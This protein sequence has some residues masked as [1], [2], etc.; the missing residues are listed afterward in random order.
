MQ[1][2]PPVH[3]RRPLRPSWRT[4]TWWG[5]SDP[6][7]QAETWY[8]HTATEITVLHHPADQA[9]LTYGLTT[10]RLCD[11]ALHWE[12]RTQYPAPVHLGIQMDNNH[13]EYRRTVDNAGGDDEAET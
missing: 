10:A 5:S 8:S 13:P 3:R 1:P 12:H 2:L 7:E 6:K 9:P 11:H 4:Y